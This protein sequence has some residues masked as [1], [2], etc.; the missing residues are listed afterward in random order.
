MT[1]PDFTQLSQFVAYAET[2]PSIMPIKAGPSKTKGKGVDPSNWGN[3]NLAEEE[4]DL[5]A[6]QAALDSLKLEFLK[7]K[8]ENT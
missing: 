8:S 5:E 3:A 2:R 1:N 4:L 6:Q 7:K